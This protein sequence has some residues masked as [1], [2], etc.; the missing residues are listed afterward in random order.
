MKESAVA[1]GEFMK[2]LKEVPKAREILAEWKIGFQKFPVPYPMQRVL[3]SE[4]S[5]S[6]SSFYTTFSRPSVIMK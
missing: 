1:F 5:A 4:S 6:E 3:L 2:C